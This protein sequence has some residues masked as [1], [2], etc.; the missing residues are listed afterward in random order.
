MEYDYRYLDEDEPEVIAEGGTRSDLDHLHFPTLQ[1]RSRETDRDPW[2]KWGDVPVVTR[3]VGKER[4]GE[5]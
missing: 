1:V 5:Q 2:S 4:D 3:K